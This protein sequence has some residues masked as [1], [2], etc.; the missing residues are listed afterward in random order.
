[1]KLKL[2]ALIPVAIASIVASSQ[3]ALVAHWNFNDLADIPLGPPGATDIPTDIPTSISSSSGSA[4]MSFANYGGRIDDALG[5]T[6]NLVTGD[7][8]G[9][10]LRLSGGPGDLG[11]TNPYSGGNGTHIDIAFSTV[12]LSD[13]IATFATSRSN[14]GYTSG[15]WSYSIDSG[16]SFLSAG[17]ADTAPA[18]SAP[19]ATATANFSAISDIEDASS[20]I[21]RYTLT[22]SGGNGGTFDIEN[23]QIN[24]V[25]EPSVSLL[26]VAAFGCFG[27]LRRR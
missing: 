25:P 21:L 6:T 4:T 22:G 3:A 13:I 9:R 18:A 15:L 12:G 24:A 1:M 7:T 5:N 14:N 23:L 2:I 10:S 17:I 16:S 27:F 20:V 11:V 19:V 8:A 26:L